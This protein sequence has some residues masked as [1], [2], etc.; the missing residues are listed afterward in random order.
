MTL[1]DRVSTKAVAEALA[2][3]EAAKPDPADAVAD[4]DLRL[5]IAGVAV[6]VQGTAEPIARSGR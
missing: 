4:D 5:G 2:H 6:L 3:Y 1:D